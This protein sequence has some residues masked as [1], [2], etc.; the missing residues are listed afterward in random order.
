MGS[1]IFSVA[2]CYFLTKKKFLESNAEGDFKFPMFLFCLTFL[3]SFDL[4]GSDL[5]ASISGT[6]F[7]CGVI[8]PESFCRELAFAT[9][10]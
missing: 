6:S 5:M 2:D 8:L 7:S 3:T 10:W 1:S 4:L 9:Y